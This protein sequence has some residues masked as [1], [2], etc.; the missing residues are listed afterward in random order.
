MQQGTGR[1]RLSKQTITQEQDGILILP[2]H[3]RTEV[4]QPD[5]SHLCDDLRAILDAT[6]QYDLYHVE[7]L[8]KRVQKWLTKSQKVLA[9]GNANNNK[10]KNNSPSR[11]FL[12][13]SATTRTTRTSFQIQLP[14]IIEGNE[15]MEWTSPGRPPLQQQ[16]LGDYGYTSSSSF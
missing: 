9:S 7:M 16:R 14:A 12:G 8:M 4:E 10:S 13:S 5:Y 3:L 15:D 1:K 2:P 6:N 11:G